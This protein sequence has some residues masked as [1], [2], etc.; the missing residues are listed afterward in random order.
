MGA[1]DERQRVAALFNLV[2]SGY[3]NAALRYFPFAADRLI[4]QM[5][6][7]PGA[8]TL[9]VATGT[10]VVALAAAQA[11]GEGG[12]VAAID[13]AEAMLDRLQE[14]IDKFGIRN[15]DL[16]VMDASSLDFRRDY[17]D[18]VVC[19]FGIFFLP[20]ML[21]ALKEWTRVLKS[22]GRTLFTCFG[23]ESFQPM[24]DMFMKQLAAYD[25]LPSG[26][27]R[28]IAAMRLAEVDQCRRLLAEADLGNI[29]VHTEQLGYHLKDETLWWDIVW[30]SGF[31]GFVGKIPAEQREAFKAEH[32]AEIRKFVTDKGLWLNVEVI[33]AAGTKT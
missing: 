4:T 24:T 19:S 32:L 1:H 15:I 21:A 31:R 30:N 2:A 18:Y 11:I 17:F 10:G 29:E 20:D 25:A 28:P 7:A 6:P 8:K 22:G 14:K 23:K 12:R 9:D 13:L 33:F 16:H 27:S 3:D 26:Q 5:Q